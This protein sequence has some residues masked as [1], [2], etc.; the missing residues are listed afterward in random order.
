MPPRS[1]QPQSSCMVQLPH[2]KTL[3]CGR[4]SSCGQEGVV[5]KVSNN[6]NNQLICIVCLQC[7][8]GAYWPAGQCSGPCCAR[9]RA[10]AGVRTVADILHHNSGFKKSSEDSAAL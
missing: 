5:R 3:H 1:A 10:L 4:C 8:E 2:A 9:L 7:N 6:K